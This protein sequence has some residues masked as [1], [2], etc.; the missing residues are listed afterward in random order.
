AGADALV[1]ATGWPEYR[2]VSADQLLAGCD[3]LLVLDANRLVPQLAAR[4]QR[5]RYLAVGMPDRDA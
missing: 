4:P 1:I 5:L 2:S 3:D